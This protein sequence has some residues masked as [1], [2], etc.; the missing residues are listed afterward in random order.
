LE[1]LE[2]FRAALDEEERRIE[3]GW[4]FIWHYKAAGLYHDQLRR[5]FD[6]FGRDQI[7]IL[8]HEDL[9]TDPLRTVQRVY[10]SIGVD[11]TFEPRSDLVYGASGAPTSQV[12]D[13][14]LF[15]ENILRKAARL[16]LPPGFKARLAAGLKQRFIRKVSVD[17]ATR[18]YLA[19][20][21]RADVIKLS[22]LI[23]KDLSAWLECPPAGPDINGDRGGLSTPGRNAR[24][25]SGA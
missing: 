16:V 23:G 21:F 9:L 4:F 25:A 19:E 14:L 10:E 1:P 7:L 20:Y 6:C 5:Y 17:D 11:P 15:K 2:S 8:F 12:A 22:Q 24:F 13:R 3:L 18:A